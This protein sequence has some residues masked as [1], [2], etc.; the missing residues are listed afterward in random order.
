M[1][2]RKTS[3][4]GRFGDIRLADAALGQLLLVTLLL[5]AR[6]TGVDGTAVQT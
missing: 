3:H 2:P 5:L 1:S 6:A 4:I